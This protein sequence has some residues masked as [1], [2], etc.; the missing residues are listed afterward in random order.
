MFLCLNY[1]K[2]VCN[3]KFKQTVAS[4]VIYMHRTCHM[5]I[6]W[7]WLHARVKVGGCITCSASSF[8]S[9]SSS[10]SSE[11]N[12]RTNPAWPYCAAALRNPAASH[13][14][15]TQSRTGAPES[16]R[17][18]T[19]D[20]PVGRAGECLDEIKSFIIVI[21]PLWCLRG[22]VF[23]RCLSGLILAHKSSSLLCS[24]L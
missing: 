16:P 11:V 9:S 23:A 1:A 17:R 15:A 18:E 10:S 3:H 6:Y 2:Q 22:V 20:T 12:R 21:F 13:P 8:S 24:F 19:L 7:R 4:F 14:L 5:N